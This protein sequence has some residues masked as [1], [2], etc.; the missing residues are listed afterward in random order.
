MKTLDSRLVY[1][2]A[3]MEVREDAIRR[4]DGSEG[5]YG[6]VDRPT[7]ALVIALDDHDRLH[8]VEQLRYP[9]GMRRWELPQGT[10]PDRAD[11]APA[12]LAQRELREE[13]GL[14]ASTWLELGT[15]DAA[16]GM[17][18]Q[19]GRVYLATGV[20]QGEPERE[21][22]EQDMISRWWTRTEIDQALRDGT[23]TDA[24]TIAALGL[25]ALHEVGRLGARG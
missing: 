12:E 2:N 18:S 16:P 1:R 19:R 7:Y 21:L 20:T 24:Q 5:I 10:A 9:L 14:S 23:I 4:P 3:W 15:L 17:T 8:L 11:V 6:V 25:L 22:E 13:T